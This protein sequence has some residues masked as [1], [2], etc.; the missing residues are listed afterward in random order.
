[1][2]I[3][4][5]TVMLTLITWFK[6]CLPDFSSVQLQLTLEQREFELY[7]YTYTWIIFSNKYYSTT[8]FWLV[9]SEDTEEAQIQRVSCK[10]Y[11]D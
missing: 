8:W 1:M 9:E 11:T 6:G 7:R 5:I 2:F 10:L 4:P 3:S